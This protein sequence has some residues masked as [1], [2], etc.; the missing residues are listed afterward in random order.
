MEQ[1]NINEYLHRESQASV[2]KKFLSDFENNKHDLQQKGE[3]TSMEIL[4]EKHIS[5]NRFTD[6][7]DIIKYDAGDIKINRLSK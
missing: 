1:L 2:I 5:L 7:I 4:A 3:Y 6:L